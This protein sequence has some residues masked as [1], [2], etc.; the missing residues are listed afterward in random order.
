MPAF[1]VVTTVPTAMVNRAVQAVKMARRCST[2]SKG[3]WSY[4][5]GSH[6]DRRAGLRAGDTASAEE[7]FVHRGEAYS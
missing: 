2:E 6:T 4:Q 1:L 3:N 7:V 5:C